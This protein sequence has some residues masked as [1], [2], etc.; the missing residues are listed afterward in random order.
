[1]GN[2][3]Q[4][5]TEKEWNEMG[6]LVNIINTETENNFISQILDNLPAEKLDTFCD[7]IPDKN[8]IPDKNVSH[9]QHYGGADNP[10]EAIK[11]IEA[12]KMDF[13]EGNVLKYLLRYKKKNGL[14]DLKKSLWYLEW[15]INRHEQ[16]G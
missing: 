2:L 16:N 13:V 10:Y 3:R 12:H 4:S 1:M 6:H 9:P 7:K 15:L 8:G 14:E 11:V 5:M